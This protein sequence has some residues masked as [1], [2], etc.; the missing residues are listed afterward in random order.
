MKTRF[1]LLL[2][3]AL[4]A[5]SFTGCKK[6]NGKGGVVT[7]NYD[8]PHFSRVHL[9]GIGRVE[10]IKDANLFAEVKTHENLFD[11]LRLEV[12][13]GKLEIGTR[14]GYSIGKYDELTYYV[15]APVIDAV[16]ISG[17]GNITGGDGIAAASFLAKVSGSGDIHISGLAASL[18]EAD[19]SGSGNIHLGGI[20]ENTKMVVSGSGNIKGFDLTSA[21]T[22]ARISGSGNIDTRTTTSLDV[23]ISGSGNV[24]Y[25]GQPSINVNISGS[26]N[27]QNAN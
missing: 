8:L 25:K 22:E 9:S 15:H 26:G 2:C 18:V 13:D 1:I 3:A 19:I 10:L 21:H 23:N 14:N 16:N 7:R 27:L 20:S 4:A 24:N 11:A 17:S 5:A 6:V 12:T